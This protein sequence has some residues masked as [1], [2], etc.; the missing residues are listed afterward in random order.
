MVNNSVAV[1]VS[2]CRVSKLAELVDRPQTVHYK[3]TEVAEL[4][5]LGE[6]LV[7][8]EHMRIFVGRQIRRS[9]EEISLAAE[10]QAVHKLVVP[11]WLCEV[12][13]VKDTDV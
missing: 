8:R 13:F 10:L 3:L 4:I 12:K 7:V 6:L 11:V 5:L 1:H 9:G 2:V